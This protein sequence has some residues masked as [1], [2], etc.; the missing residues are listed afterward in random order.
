MRDCPS[1]DL[2]SVL[3][4]ATDRE[5]NKEENGHVSHHRCSLQ[6][7]TV[8]PKREAHGIYV[9]EGL[10]N[11]TFERLLQEDKARAGLPS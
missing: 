6:G 2:Y 5:Q 4:K 3:C 7:Y 10:R 8:S 9:L 11:T 1:D